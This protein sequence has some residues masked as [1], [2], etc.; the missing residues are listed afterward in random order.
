MRIKLI[1]VLLLGCLCILSTPAFAAIY[2]M[3]A[4]DGANNSSFNMAGTWT[5]TGSGVPA[6]GN[7]YYTGGYLMR[8]PAN[9]TTYLSGPFTFAGDKLTIGYSSTGTLS[10]P[11]NTNGAVNNNSLLFKLSNQ[12]LTVNNLVLDAGCVRDGLGDA[13]NWHLAG[14][15]FVTTNGGQFLCQSAGYVDSVISGPGPIYIGD[16]GGGGASRVIHFTSAAS[17]YAGNII[18]APGTS[19]NAAR[20]RMALDDNAIMNFVIGAS[21]VNNS[22]SGNG[23]LTLNGDFAFNL[24]GATSNLYDAWTIAS[25]TS[26]SFGDTFT[27]K[28][29]TDLGGNLWKKGIDVDKWY[30]FNEATGKLSVVPEPATWIM[31]VLGAMG[32]ALYSRKR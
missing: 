20:S 22:I 7:D 31:L 1:F 16:N 11:F 14:N 18:L 8:S 30:Q 9:G 27:V 15:I 13:D 4:G 3:S 6:A 23:T 28:D 5:P 19:G 21:G 29:F 2:N 26:Q 12:T 17:T 25:A 24:T 10:T 32:I